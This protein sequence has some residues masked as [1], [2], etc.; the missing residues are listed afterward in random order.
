MSP[1]LRQQ[2]ES[3]DH[4]P[5]QRSNAT[6]KSFVDPKARAIYD[7]KDHP[8]VKDDVGYYLE[9]DRGG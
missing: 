2:L 4:G 1:D 7:V 8:S 5:C 6:S 3:R 9:A